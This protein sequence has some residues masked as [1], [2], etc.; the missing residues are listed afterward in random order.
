MIDWSIGVQAATILLREGLEA[1]LVIAALAAFLRRSGAE[2]R[3]RWLYGGALAAIV[4]SFGAAWVFER[5][6]GGAHSDLFEAAVMVL[7]AGLM[8][9]MSGWLVLRQDPRAWQA[10]LRRSAERALDSGAAWSIAGVAFLAV[11]REGGE[12]V[13]FLHALAVNAASATGMAAGLAVA[14]LGLAVLFWAIEI[15]AAR[16]PLRPVFLATSAVLFLTGLKLVGDAVQELQEQA[17]LPFDANAVSEAV[18]GFGTN[19]SL[20]A[21]GLQA[22]IL[23]LAGLCYLLAV[24]PRLRRESAA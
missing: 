15:V 18:R 9:Y 16:L 3:L 19:G 7:A 8:F 22:S 13:L 12:T 24:R 17:I 6:F 14:A 23:V 1:M 5:F 10:S 2:S 21:L 20:E 11:F 4:A